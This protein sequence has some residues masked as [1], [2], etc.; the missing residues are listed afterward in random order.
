MINKKSLSNLNPGIPVTWNDQEFKS[1]SDLSRH[2]GIAYSTLHDRF[3]RDEE[4]NGFYID[5]L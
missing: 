3:N 4:I 5:Y 2:L 1:L